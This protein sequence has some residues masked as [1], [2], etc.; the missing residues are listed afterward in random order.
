MIWNV[1]NIMWTKLA[2]AGAIVCT[3]LWA[4]GK[5]ISATLWT[6]I[7]TAGTGIVDAARLLKTKI[8]QRWEA[9]GS[10]DFHHEEPTLALVPVR[11]MH[12]P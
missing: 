11:I 4:T 9:A 12:A 1:G 7:C 3:P 2:T 8:S 6:A 10:D 5:A